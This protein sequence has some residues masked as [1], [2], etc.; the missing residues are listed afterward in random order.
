MMVLF[1]IGYIAYRPL[2]FELIVL[3]S[4]KSFLAKIVTK[5]STCTIQID[6]NKYKPIWELRKL[7]SWQQLT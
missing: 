3:Q 1:N 2:W 7:D 6:P 4:Y 5:W